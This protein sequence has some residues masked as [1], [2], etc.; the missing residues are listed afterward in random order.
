MDLFSF[1]PGQLKANEMVRL[2]ATRLKGEYFIEMEE[3]GALVEGNLEMEVSTVGKMLT[4]RLAIRRNRV[5]SRRVD[6]RDWSVNLDSLRMRIREL[7][8][9]AAEKGLLIEQ[10]AVHLE[11]AP[12]LL[13]DRLFRSAKEAVE[14]LDEFCPEAL[15]NPH[16][17][18][19]RTSVNELRSWTAEA[20]HNSSPPEG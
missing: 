7:L 5:I 4:V 10:P 12:A 18:A 19:L 2:L 13:I 15:D 9:I 17:S 11:N 14:W 16:L 20:E 1:P 8:G 3:F 6:I